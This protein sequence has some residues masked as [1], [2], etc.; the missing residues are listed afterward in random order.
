MR[1]PFSRRQAL[2]LG[3]SIFVVWVGACAR[4][5]LGRQAHGPIRTNAPVSP[6]IIPMGQPIPKGGGIYKV[7]EPYLIDGAL[8][9]PAEDP[10]YDRTGIASFYSEDF[11]GRRTANGE[12]FD[13]WALTAAH[14]TLPIP[15]YAYVTNL[16]NG[17]TL[18]VRINDR[19]P[20]ARGRIIDLS[21]AAARLLAFETSGTSTVRVRYAGPAPLN[22]DDQYE[23][24]FLASQNWY[25]IVAWNGA[26]LPRNR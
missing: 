10:S 2:S 19:G 11:H 26:G 4:G 3:L 8:F 25:R 21:R 23:Q 15:S 22:G 5:D 9:T 18:L 1:M 12:I 24:R 14:P 20:Y 7:G 17:R 13:M 16:A 6:R